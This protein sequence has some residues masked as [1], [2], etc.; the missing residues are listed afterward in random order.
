MNKNGKTIAIILGLLLALAMPLMAHSQTATR[1][2]YLGVGAGQAEAVNYS[3][4]VCDPLL[5]TDCKKKSDV[6]RFFGGWQFGRNWGVE[7]AYTDLGK[8]TSTIPGTFDQTV[9]ARVGEM[10]LV[11]SWPATDRIAFYGKVGGYYGNATTE[12]TQNGVTQ[13][14]NEGRGNY[15]FAAGIQWYMTPRLALR[16]EGQHYVKVGTTVA[17]LDY[18]VYT[19]G[20]LFKFQ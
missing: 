15:T 11:G 8:I 13:Q 9:K 5:T 12:T 18:N 2:V 3:D 10:T 7:F 6:F 20:L 16:G 19:V 1:G 17:D 4:R 14:V